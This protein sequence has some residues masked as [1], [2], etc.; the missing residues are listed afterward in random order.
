[1][2]L[3]SQLAGNV[4][5]Q[6]SMGIL[7]VALTIPLCTGAMVIASAL[8]GRAFLGEPLDRHLMTALAILTVSIFLFQNQSEAAVEN[9]SAVRLDVLQGWSTLGGVLGAIV[10]GIAF[11][12]LS[13][14]IRAV[15][16][17]ETSR[18]MPIVTVSL[19]GVLVICP[20]AL[21]RQGERIGEVG[22]L[23]WEM[24]VLAGLGNA[25]AFLCLAS[26]LKLLPVAWVNAV[27]VL[28][29]ALATGIGIFLFGEPSS[30]WLWTGLAMMSGGFFLLIRRGS[31]GAGR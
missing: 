23:K 16:S 28:Q 30:Y 5:L 13:V 21:L 26:S 31:R 3:V 9:L 14:T 22:I 11:A 20:V 2:S 17:T 8:L 18:L 27:N 12:G 10:P 24:M 15:L 25:L 19:V 7:G 1:V 6:Y 4:L 29:V